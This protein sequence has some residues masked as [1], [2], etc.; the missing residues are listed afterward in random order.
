MQTKQLEKIRQWF[1]NYVGSFYGNDEYFNAN[2]ELK[3]K[4]SRL[5]CKETL[6][7]A[8]TL[9]L[10]NE[11]KKT[12]EVIGL[13]HDVGRFVQFEKYRTYNDPK[14]VNHS[15]LGV[16]VIRQEGVLASLEPAEIRCIET[17][18]TLHGDKKLP[19]NLDGEILLQSKLIRDADKIDI[20]RVV[21]KYYEQY[22]QNPNSFKLE[23][24]LPDEP[25]Y[26]DEVLEKILQGKLI[27]YR[28]LKTWNDCKLVQLSWVYDVNFVAT[29]KRIK[30]RGF[31]E[32]IIDFLPQNDDI[33]QV[34]KIVIEFVNN[35]INQT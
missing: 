23:V 21:T 6:Y 14:S 35:Q 1:D 22:K 7:L 19:D 11:Q 16:E 17:A 25:W 29:F 26:S 9:G 32:K 20:Y 12:A 34:G 5:V 33:K 28:S 27:D 4:H 30:E 24:E 8:D 2:I 18:I 10:T 31:L 3:D 13:L 15:R